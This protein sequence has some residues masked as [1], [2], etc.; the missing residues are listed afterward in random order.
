MSSTNF[1]SNYDPET[2]LIV[3]QFILHYQYHRKDGDSHKDWFV[4]IV[5]PNRTPTMEQETNDVMAEEVVVDQNSLIQAK[6]Q[7]KPTADRT[8]RKLIDKGFSRSDLFNPAKLIPE[9]GSH[10]KLFLYRRN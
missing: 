5:P 1:I 10:Y 6:I 8:L 9:S 4:G 7:G 3:G 2:V